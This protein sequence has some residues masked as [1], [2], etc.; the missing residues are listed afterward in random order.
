MFIN[1]RIKKY[2]EFKGLSQQKFY[3]QTGLSNG[4]LSSKNMRADNIEIVVSTYGDLNLYWLIT[5]KGS[6]LKEPEKEKTV[7]EPQTSEFLRRFEE[8]AAENALL[9]A[10]VAELEA[11]QDED[12]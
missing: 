5:G 7:Q 3:K 10:R 6:M 11:R 4:S 9:K 8:L 2:L 12:R 1:D